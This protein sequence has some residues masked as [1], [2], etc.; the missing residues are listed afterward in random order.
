M[1]SRWQNRKRTTGQEVCAVIE[2]RSQGLG[3]GDSETAETDVQFKSSLWLGGRRE[4]EKAALDGTSGFW[5]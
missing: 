3:L 2:R 4:G 5:K 1:G